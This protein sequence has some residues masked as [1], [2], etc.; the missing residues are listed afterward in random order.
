MMG[1]SLASK[2][3]N[4]GQFRTICL[5][6]I[7]RKKLHQPTIVSSASMPVCCYLV[8][9]LIPIIFVSFAG[10]IHEYLSKSKTSS[11]ENLNVRSTSQ[12]SI[13]SILKIEFLTFCFFFVIPPVKFLSIPCTHTVGFEVFGV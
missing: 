12:Y 9:P 4:C 7:P 10:D 5:E 2:P 1:C 6:Q 8:I 3:P 11:F 13:I